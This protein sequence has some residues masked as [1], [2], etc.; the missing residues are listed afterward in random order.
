MELPPFDR[1]AMDGWVVRAEDTSDAGEGT[2][3]VLTVDGDLAAGDAGDR[4][5]AAGHA[6]RI[7]TGAPLP[8]GADAIV[9]L[10]DGEEIDGALHTEIPVPRGRHVRYRGEDVGSGDTLLAPGDPIDAAALPLLASSGVTHVEAPRAA[11][12]ALITTGSELV[13]PGGELAPGQIYESNLTALKVLAGQAGCDLLDL[14]IVRDD[15]PTIGAALDHAARAADLMLI[16][17]GVSVGPHDHVRSLLDERG[18]RQIFWRVKIKPGKPVLAGRLNGTW[19][20]GLPGNPLSAVAGFLLFA[21]PL[22]RRLHGHPAQPPRTIPVRLHVPAGPS[23]NR[24]TLLTSTL[25]READGSLTATPTEAQGS[26]MT[27]SLAQADGFVI[28]GHG[29]GELPAGAMAPFL[30]LPGRALG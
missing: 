1:T 30:P 17:G 19:V 20:L 14:G 25:A 29:S 10:E 6:R 15:R 9:R 16:T 21:A 26:H 27:A 11:R 5:L 18:L 7:S 8:P 28:I 4:P 22:I 23:D 24:T 12:V 2:P 13:S 3:A